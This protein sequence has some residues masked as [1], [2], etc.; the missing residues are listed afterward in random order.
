[1][2][3]TMIHD[4]GGRSCCVSEVSIEL[5]VI[6]LMSLNSGTRPCQVSELFVLIQLEKMDER[7]LRA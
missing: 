6:A 5:D 7:G 2:C 1:M 3:G 4:E